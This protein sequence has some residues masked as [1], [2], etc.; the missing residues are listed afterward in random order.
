MTNETINL[1][2]EELENLSIKALVASGTK[3]EN[4]RSV[5]LSLV[6]AEAEG[7]SGNGIVRLPTFCEH[8]RCRKVDGYAKPTCTKI[9]LSA[10][11]VDARDGFAHPAIDLGIESI[12]PL[13]KASGIVAMAI[14][15]SYNCGVVGY[16]VER[17]AAEGLIALGFVNAPA[18][19]APWGGSK[20]IYGTNPIAFAAPRPNTYPIV[21]D[22]SSSVVSKGDVIVAAQNGESIPEGWVLSKD[23]KPTTDPNEIDRGGTMVPSGGYKGAGMALLVEIM[24]AVLT[25]SVL[26]VQ[27]SSF[28]DNEGGPPRTGQVFIA[29]QPNSFSGSRYMEQIEMLVKL[30][31]DQSG[32]RLPGDRR[33][34]IRKQST[35]KGV[36]LGKELYEKILAYC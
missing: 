25:G 2:L 18:S 32:T 24:A 5:A 15:N 6:S 9:S 16:H 11:R 12:V 20:A 34:K 13:T 7:N 31:L 27:A 3:E 33:T 36:S 19:I 17:I 8:V 28:A 22:Q 23:G 4:A 30:I 10:L 14:T 21:I 29:I 26:S 1:K 35:E